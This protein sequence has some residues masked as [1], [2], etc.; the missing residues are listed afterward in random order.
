MNVVMIIMFILSVVGI[1]EIISFL[2]YH[3]M[4]VSQEKS[5]LLITPVDSDNYEM[6]IRSAISKAKWLGSFRPQKI[7]ILTDSLPE[8]ILV[9]IENLIYGY[10][11]IEIKDKKDVPYV[12]NLL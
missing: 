8:D 11:Y 5:I 9:D 4:S 6:V 1:V 7:I 12:S 2:A 10:N 3:M